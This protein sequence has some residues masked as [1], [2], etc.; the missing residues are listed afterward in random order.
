[1]ETLIIKFFNDKKR[2]NDEDKE[3]W[4]SICL[5]LLKKIKTL[6]PSIT[7]TV[8]DMFSDDWET[9]TLDDH[10]T[11]GRYVNKLSAIGALPLNYVHLN[12]ARACVYEIIGS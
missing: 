3:Y 8:E 2:M 11:V 9:I 5:Q 10:K 12:L 4:L 7:Y 6:N 1:M